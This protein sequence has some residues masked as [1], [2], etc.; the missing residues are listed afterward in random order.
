MNMLLQQSR[1][2]SDNFLNP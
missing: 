2:S 1:K